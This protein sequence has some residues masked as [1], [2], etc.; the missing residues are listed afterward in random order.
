ML[1]KDHKHIVLNGLFLEMTKI[2]TQGFFFE[3]FQGVLATKQ[4]IQIQIR[5]FYYLEIRSKLI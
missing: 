4:M 3:L 2:I 1:K 5:L